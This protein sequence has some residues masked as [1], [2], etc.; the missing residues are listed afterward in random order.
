L[1]KKGFKKERV[2]AIGLYDMGTSTALESNKSLT[3]IHDQRARHTR[4]SAREFL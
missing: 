2:T 1:K 4:T 3:W